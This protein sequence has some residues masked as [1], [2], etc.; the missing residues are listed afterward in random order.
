[1][2]HRKFND[3]TSL[4]LL[5]NNSVT[6]EPIVIA[7]GEEKKK[8][9]VHAHLLRASSKYFLEALS[10]THMG[11]ELQTVPLP[12]ADANAF[13]IYA[14]W[15]YTGCF[16]LANRPGTDISTSSPTEIH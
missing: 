11:S 6:S 9:L 8:F 4:T 5:I 13:R 15:L 3:R 12:D 14:K 1:M 16:H 2:A 7:V 10:M